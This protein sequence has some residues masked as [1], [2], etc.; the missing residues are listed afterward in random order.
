[1]LSQSV[2][3]R[4]AASMVSEDVSSVE[5]S[6]LSQPLVVPLDVMVVSNPVL[7]VSLRERTR[8]S[9][10]RNL[11]FRRPISWAVAKS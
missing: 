8:S 9:P 1:M 2:L 6:K 4:F 10:L 7:S 11:I 3:A 5:M